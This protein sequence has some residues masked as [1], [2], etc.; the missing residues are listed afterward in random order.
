MIKTW[1]TLV[2]SFGTVYRLPDAVV[3]VNWANPN[4]S[5]KRTC[6][7]LL[8]RRHITDRVYFVPFTIQLTY[9][10]YWLINL[11][12]FSTTLIT[13]NTNKKN[14]QWKWNMQFSNV[15]V[16]AC[17]LQEPNSPECSGNGTYECGV[18]VCNDSYYGDRCQCDETSVDAETHHDA[19][20]VYARWCRIHCLFSPRL[21]FCPFTDIL[22]LYRNIRNAINTSSLMVGYSLW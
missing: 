6:L 19:C 17:I 8:I 7:G 13:L 12:S 15:F 22:W 20:R 9:L 18:C 5:W 1:K 16:C 11:M 10:A 2:R 21:Y 3:T 4:D 14:M